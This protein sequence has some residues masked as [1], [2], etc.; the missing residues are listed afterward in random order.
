MI[1]NADVEFNS[2]MAAFEAKH[3]GRACQLLGPFAE[4]GNA[5]AQHRLAIMYQNGLG[6][7]V[8]PELAVKWMRAAAEQGHAWPSTVW[9]LCI[10]RVSVWIKIPRKR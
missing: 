10:S 2:A 4:Q 5:D 7:A 6:V 9:G 3:F 8:N 1:D